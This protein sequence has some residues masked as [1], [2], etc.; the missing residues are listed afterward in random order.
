MYPSNF[1]LNKKIFSGSITRYVAIGDE[2]TLLN[3]DAEAPLRMKIGKTISD[4]FYGLDFDMASCSFT[5]RVN[6]REIYTQNFD[7]RLTSNAAL[8]GILKYFTLT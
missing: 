2:A 6:P 4:V 3:F 8:N 5:N 7:W 1:V